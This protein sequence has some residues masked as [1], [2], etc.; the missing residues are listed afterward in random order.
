[1]PKPSNGSVDKKAALYYKIVGP[2]T[3]VV[4]DDFKVEWAR[5]EG[6]DGLQKALEFIKNYNNE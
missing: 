5:Y 4:F 6:T 1:M 2:S 3:V